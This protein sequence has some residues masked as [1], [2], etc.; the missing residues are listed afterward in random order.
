MVTNQTPTT[1][2][3]IAGSDSSGGAGI[4]MDLRTAAELHCRCALAVTAVTAQTADTVH[5]QLLVP[6]EEI[7][8]QINCANADPTLRAIK[9]G[10]LGSQEIVETVAEQLRTS[11]VYNPTVIDPVLISSSGFPLLAKGAYPALL[12]DLMPQATVITPN[13]DEAA[14]LLGSSP[15]VTLDDAKTQ[16]KALSERAGCSV[17]LKGGHR[18]DDQA[19]DILVIGETI[20]ELS[21]P[22]LSGTMRGTGCA[23]STAIACGLARNLDLE[24]ACRDAKLYVWQQIENQ[25]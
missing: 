12:D 25:S 5:S 22:R 6:I 18:A 21:S 19:I 17:L 23:L 1:I 13:A 4:A 14:A 3:T 16:A 9:I 20:V 7:Q 15:A 24:Q 8:V 11:P 10:M 2:L